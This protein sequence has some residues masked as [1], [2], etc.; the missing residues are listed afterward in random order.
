MRRNGAG[1]A[2][3]MLTLVAS[4]APLAAQRTTTVPQLPATAAAR[5]DR[6]EVSLWPE[7]DRLAMLVLY[8]ATLPAQAK[9]PA[10]VTLLIPAIVG[11]P[12][13]VAA[14]GADGRLLN[15]QFTREVAGEWARVVIL[16]DNPAVQLEYYAEL[17]T[18]GSKRRFA[19]SWPGGPE[20]GAL[21]FEVQQPPTASNLTLTPAALSQSVHDD[22]L[23]YHRAELGA[24]KAG[25]S[26]RLELTYEKPSAALTAPQSPASPPPQDAAASP[27]APTNE[28]TSPTD[29]ALLMVFG[30]V[31]VIVVA[32]FMAT[33]PG[34]K[35]K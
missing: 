26:A 31:A 21:T 28:P 22:G 35:K 10:T 34:I 2:V 8:R 14:R 1:R 25:A 33:R 30:L 9:L 17:A 29:P 4:A 7:Y 24:V 23:T 13:A 27:A 15:A 11:V 12:H 6:L 32:F 16:T 18:D 3:L 19:F 5:L 20:I